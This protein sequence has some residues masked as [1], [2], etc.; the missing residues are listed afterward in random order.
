M[1]WGHGVGLADVLV[2]VALHTVTGWES[3]PVSI[4]LSRSFTASSSLNFIK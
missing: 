2:A 3:R 1:R 4:A